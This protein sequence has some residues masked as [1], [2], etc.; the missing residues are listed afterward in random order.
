MF[1][2]WKKEQSVLHCQKPFRV[3]LASILGILSFS[4][5]KNVK[6]KFVLFDENNLFSQLQGYSSRKKSW[7]NESSWVLCTEQ[8]S[9]KPCEAWQASLCSCEAGLHTGA[10]NS[11]PCYSNS[12]WFFFAIGDCRLDSVGSSASTSTLSSPVISHKSVQRAQLV[13]AIPGATQRFIAAD[14]WSQFNCTA[15]SLYASLRWKAV[16]MFGLISMNDINLWINSQ[17]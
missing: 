8:G 1:F 10:S 12:F 16:Q 3:S 2:Q 7:S 5:K 14:T 6:L 15:H 4:E 13:W 17:F 9:K 11:P